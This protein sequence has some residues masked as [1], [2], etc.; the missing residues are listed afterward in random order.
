MLKDAAF[1]GYPDEDEAVF[2]ASL[3]NPVAATV[4]ASGGLYSSPEAAWS[5]KVME[6]IEEVYQRETQSR[7]GRER[8]GLTDTALI[9]LLKHLEIRMGILITA[10]ATHSVG[11]TARQI[12]TILDM[13]DTILV[14]TEHCTIY[15]DMQKCR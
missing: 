11:R 14:T 3:T 10:M 12:A 4:W 5:D 6:A 9:E 8:M 2:M 1:Y 7:K 15:I 13:A